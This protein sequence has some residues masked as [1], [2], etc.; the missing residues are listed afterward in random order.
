M[1]EY[2]ASLEGTISWSLICDYDNTGNNGT[3]RDKLSL[4]TSESIQYEV[5]KTSFNR[6]IRSDLRRRKTGGVGASYKALLAKVDYASADLSTEMIE[7][8]EATTTTN[9]K[10]NLSKTRSYE[11]NM[12]VGPYSKLSLYQQRFSAPGMSVMG[13][14]VS[15]KPP[16]PQNITIEYTVQPIRFISDILLL[17]LI[18]A[19]TTNVDEA[20]TGFDLFIQGSA[21]DGWDDLAKDAGGSFR[22]IR[23]KK[24]VN[25]PRKVPMSHY[26]ALMIRS[27]ISLHL[28]LATPETSTQIAG[29]LPLPIVVLRNCLLIVDDATG[30]IESPGSTM[31][32]YTI[33]MQ[34]T[35]SWHL[36]LDYDSIDLKNNSTI[37]DK[38]NVRTS[39]SIQ[40]EVFKQ[41]LNRAV[42]DELQRCHT[43]EIGASYKALLATVDHAPTD[44][45]PEIIET[46]ETTAW[47]KL[48]DDR[49]QIGS[50][51]CEVHAGAL[52]KLSLYQQRFTAPGISVLSSMLSTKP[53][54]TRPVIVKY[55]VRPIRFVSE[56]K[57][58]Y[59]ERP[60][61]APLDRVTEIS[62]RSD[63][64]NDKCGGCCVWLV[65]TYTYRVDEAATRFEV[66][67]QDDR[68]K[69]WDSVAKEAAGPYRY[70][71]GVKDNNNPSKVTDVALLRSVDAVSH[72]PSP[73]VR[74]TSD[75]NA[76]RT[77]AYLHLMWSTE[78]AC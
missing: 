25:Q 76:G 16:P 4:M 38:R 71:R 45:S 39:S 8:I 47:S 26:S 20:A 51:E 11:R 62:G 9:F 70:I 10:A 19:H 21:H 58:C 42:R 18:P 78:T 41:R 23:A 53:S 12:L 49:F 2:T 52:S 33:T 28:T 7:T 50:V 24:D 40:C 46:I 37:R 65:P 43:D 55:T 54:P 44:I 64:I 3:I 29:T 66:F 57:V 36:L 56:I 15:T 17:W 30:V 60:S 1:A 67:I 77:D 5:F 35:L 59:G 68:H 22:Y 72:F 14:A 61:D 34:G 69:G 32:E 48:D 27:D 6:T 75:I 31:S 73:Y 74:H 13:S 63:N